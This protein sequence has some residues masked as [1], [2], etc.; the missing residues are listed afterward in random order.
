MI[1]LSIL[2]L[3]YLLPFLIP[4]FRNSSK[5]LWSVFGEISVMPAANGMLKSKSAYSDGRLMSMNV[6][7]RNF[8]EPQ[9]KDQEI[10]ALP[11][12]PGSH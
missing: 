10:L 11:H 6:C 3:L 7:K 2:L 4:L 5:N 8:I 9:A 1:I 12:L